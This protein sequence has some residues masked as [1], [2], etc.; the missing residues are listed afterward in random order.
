MTVRGI[1]HVSLV[2]SMLPASNH[3]RTTVIS[4]LPPTLLDTLHLERR[5]WTFSFLDQCKCWARNSR[6]SSNISMTT[7]YAARQGFWRSGRQADGNASRYI[8]SGRRCKASVP[9]RCTRNR[10]RT[11]YLSSM[12][13]GFTCVAEN[14]TLCGVCPPPSLLTV[15]RFGAGK[16]GSEFP[17]VIPLL[18]VQGFTQ[19]HT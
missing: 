8:F 13:G 2:K 6:S 7:V 1:T 9:S 10:Y 16:N 17:T 18:R 15:C 3:Y 4:C 19:S 11:R 5:V 14:S 12:L